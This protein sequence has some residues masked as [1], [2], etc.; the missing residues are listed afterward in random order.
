[1]FSMLSPCVQ[2]V[3]GKIILVVKNECRDVEFLLLLN[4]ILSLLK[5]VSENQDKWMSEYFSGD[6]FSSER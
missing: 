6:K 5:S 2:D 3:Y 4:L 1:M